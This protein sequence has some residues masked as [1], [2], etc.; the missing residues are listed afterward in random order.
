[1]HPTH[2]NP[3]A[4]SL[5]VRPDKFEQLQEQLGLDPDKLRTLADW[6]EALLSN[7]HSPGPRPT[8]SEAEY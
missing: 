8:H 5:R 1:M 6:A 2:H 4:A 3:N 7:N